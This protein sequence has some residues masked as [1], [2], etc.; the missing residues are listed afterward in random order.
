MEACSAEPVAICGS[1][2]AP[3]SRRWVRSSTRV[4][5]SWIEEG[6]QESRPS[7][8]GREVELPIED[9]AIQ[10]QGEVDREAPG[11][12]EVL[13]DVTLGDDRARQPIA[14]DQTLHGMAGIGDPALASGRGETAGQVVQV[15]VEAVEEL[16][17]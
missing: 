3:A 17:G 2:A 12:G 13:P 7:C 9:G 15:D 4:G 11:G 6:L 8:R 14:V 10:R 16:E 5:A 1:T